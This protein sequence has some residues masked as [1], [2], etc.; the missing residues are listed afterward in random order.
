MQNY[1]EVCR[2]ITAAGSPISRLMAAI[3]VKSDRG[4]M[5]L[6]ISGVSGE[7]ESGKYR[8]INQG[9]NQGV[10]ANIGSLTL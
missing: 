1:A 5:S 4:V 9:V 6:T 7:S 3:G 8:H 2:G 10:L